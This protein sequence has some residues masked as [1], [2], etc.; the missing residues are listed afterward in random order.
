MNNMNYI[1]KL[2]SR[3]FQMSIGSIFVTMGAALQGE[4]RWDSAILAIVA[5]AI[6][7]IGVEGAIDHAREK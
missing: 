5:V 4:I 3:K 7:Y 6:A 1:D 2:K